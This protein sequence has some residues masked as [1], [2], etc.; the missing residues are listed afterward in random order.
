MKVNNKG[1]TGA[2][3]ED[4]FVYNLVMVIVGL[5]I[6]LGLTFG[7]IGTLKADVEVDA[8]IVAID[9][10]THA[11]QMHVLSSDGVQIEAGQLVS[12]RRSGYASEFW[13]IGD[14]VNLTCRWARLDQLVAKCWE[15]Q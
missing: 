2:M 7:L 11:I 14:V 1:A 5:I 4:A 12:T 6:V 3:L 9:D 8:T 13:R 10:D 15:Y